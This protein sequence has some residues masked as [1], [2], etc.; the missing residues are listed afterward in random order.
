MQGGVRAG[1]DGDGGMERASDAESEVETG[2]TAGWEA[3][4]SNVFCPEFSGMYKA[5]LKDMYERHTNGKDHAYWGTVMV[6]PAWQRCGIGSAIVQWALENLR[7]DTMP[8]FLNAQPDGN[9]LY[10]KYGWLDVKNFDIDLSDCAGPNRGGELFEAIQNYSTP[11]V[12]KHRN[13]KEVRRFIVVVVVP[14]IVSVS[15]DLG[16]V[17]RVATIIAA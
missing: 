4:V 5:K 16:F 9:R 6:L 14:L 8:V 13:L 10:Q 12:G 3:D 2:N 15:E 17:V 11:K 7:L 1:K